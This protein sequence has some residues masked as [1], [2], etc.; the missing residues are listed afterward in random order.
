MTLLQIG[1]MPKTLTLKNTKLFA[2]QVMPEI[3]KMWPDYDDN[4]WPANV[5]NNEPLIAADD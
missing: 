1:S 3:N 5:T 2:E 4:W